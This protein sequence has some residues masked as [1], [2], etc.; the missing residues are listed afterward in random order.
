MTGNV[1]DKDSDIEYKSFFGSDEVDRWFAIKSPIVGVGD[2]WQRDDGR[3]LVHDPR[4][5]CK[6]NSRQ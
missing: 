6:G 5:M 1:R 2:F 4:L 3:V